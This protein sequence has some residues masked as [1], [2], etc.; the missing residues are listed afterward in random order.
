MKVILLISSNSSSRGGGERYLIFLAEGLIQI[1]IKVHILLSS[2]DFMD[3]WANELTTIGAFV[4]RKK[5]KN[6]N[7]RPLR[8]IQAIMDFN[9]QN[10]IKNICKEINPIAIIVNQ[11]YD[12]DGLDYLIGALKSKINPVFGIIHMPMTEFKNKRPLGRIRGVILYY[13]Y[14]KN[15]YNIIFS[16]S[17]SNNEFIKYYKL[18]ISSNVV[19]S[20]I[21]FEN[22]YN[23]KL[24]NNDIK[25]LNFIKIDN[26]NKKIPVIGFAGQF[27][28]QKNIDLLI[29][30][31]L[32]LFIIG[33]STKLLLIG[34]GP[35]R[36]KIEEK[37]KQTNKS[38][39]WYITGWTEEYFR[40]LEHLDIFIML[41]RFEG[42]PLT[43]IEAV[44][45]GI[46]TI[47]TNFNGAYE[48]AARATW[49]DIVEDNSLNTVTKYLIKK[50]NETSNQKKID[51]SE[52][53]SFVNYFSSKRMALDMFEII[54]NKGVNK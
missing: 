2:S 52:I 22:T 27:V 25:W 48:I 11:Q 36:E 34:D 14:K 51:N 23:V 8:F 44:G 3:G 9:Q 20:G 42:L 33:I 49:V 19:N 21:K 15:P 10:S 35:N 18:N 1:G 32:N 45:R 37:L 53:N 4:H 41:S 31:W 54:K 38:D 24:N 43:L 26:K 46:P 17:A 40:Y 13:W 16:S 47:I 6:L 28:D 30:T 39:L 29:D 7:E 50:L 12:E 5:L